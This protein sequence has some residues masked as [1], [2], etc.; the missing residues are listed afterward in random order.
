[1]TSKL[2]ERLQTAGNVGI[3]VGLLLVG[4]QLSQN[5]DLL[6]TQLLYEESRRITELESQ[7]IGENAADVWAKSIEH[8]E[9]LTLA[10]QRIMEALLWTYVEEW[11]GI[12][13]L[14]ELGLLEDNEWRKRIENETLFVLGNRYALA[15][16]SNFTQGGSAL[17]GELVEVVDNELANGDRDRT[18]NYFRDIMDELRNP[19]SAAETTSE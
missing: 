6:K 14:A 13:M 12:N 1:M 19:T 2:N 7:Y 9:E 17:P 16:W 18:P 10:E 11:R 15:W 4:V 5:S 8:P 3:I